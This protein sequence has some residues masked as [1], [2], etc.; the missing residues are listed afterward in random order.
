M[1][2]FITSVLVIEWVSK[3]GWHQCMYPQG[4]FQL[5][6]ASPVSLQDQQVSLT[7]APFKLL[8]LHWVPDH[9]KFCVPFKNGVSC[10]PQSLSLPKNSPVVILSLVWL[11]AAPWTVACQGSL[12][13]EFSRQRFWSGV[14]FATPGDL[15]NPRSKPTSLESPTLTGGFFTTSTICREGNGCPLQYSHLENPMD[16]GAWW[17]AVHG[18]TKSR[19]QLSNFLFTFMHW[20]RKWQPTPA[21]LPGESQG[22]G[23]LVGCRLWGRTGSDKTKAT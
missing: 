18:V 1:A 2:L 10:L 11:F 21:F 16:G 22:W 3:N 6:P 9:V 20:R 13:M 7:L 4:K 14:P 19:T 8:L 5:L 15:P 23:S 17:A 12:P